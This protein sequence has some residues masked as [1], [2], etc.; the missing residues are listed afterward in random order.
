[1][2]RA[3]RAIYPRI[4]IFVGTGLILIG[5]LVNTWTLENRYL[6][7]DIRIRAPLA[8]ALIYAFQ[9]VT[10]AA[11]LLLLFT[12]PSADWI[13]LITITAVLS[14]GAVETASRIWLAFS[15][16]RRPKA[17][18]RAFHRHSREVP[19]IHPPPLFELCPKSWGTV[20]AAQLII[21]LGF[22]GK[23]L[24]RLEKP[25]GI[26]RIVTVG[27]STTSHKAQLRTMQKGIRLSWK[28]CS[29]DKFGY[30]RVQVVNAGVSGYD[31]WECL[32]NIEFKVLDVK[33]DLIIVYSAFNDISARL[34]E[35]VRVSW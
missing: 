32:M 7:H 19:S 4:Y 17:F 27:G 10:V 34:V 23:E 8:I 29:R 24:C 9:F 33:P 12:R 13:L 22:R 21:H 2:V 18:L 14:F 5:C 16:N 6:P 30:D 3:K 15:C 28:E 31:S 25:N 26:F 1:M 20:T 11:G 35:P